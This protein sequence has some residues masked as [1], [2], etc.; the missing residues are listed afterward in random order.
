M[1]NGA[2]CTEAPAPTCAEGSSVTAE[3]GRSQQIPVRC[4]K[5]RHLQIMFS[6]FFPILI[7]FTVFPIALSGAS[8]TI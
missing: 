4:P 2:K 6:F 7:P 8:S 5:P 3:S 1:V